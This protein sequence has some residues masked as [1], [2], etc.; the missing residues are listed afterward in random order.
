MHVC[1]IYSVKKLANSNLLQ[2][3][4]ESLIRFALTRSKLLTFL[5]QSICGW[6]YITSQHTDALRKLG[7]L[8]IKLLSTFPLNKCWKLLVWDS[9]DILCGLVAFDSF[10]TASSCIS[11]DCRTESWILKTVE[12]FV[13]TQ[14]NYFNLHISFPSPVLWGITYT[15]HTKIRNIIKRQ[16]NRDNHPF[17]FRCWFVCIDSWELP[18]TAVQQHV[19]A[20]LSSC[21]LRLHPPHCG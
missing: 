12:A 18:N 21:V 17:S 1:D 6:T 19:S 7:Y 4:K 8:H 9:W 3:Y 10:E 20:C 11:L 2:A 15:A 16:S 14:C 5:S 13:W